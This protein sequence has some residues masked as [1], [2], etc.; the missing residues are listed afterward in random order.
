MDTRVTNLGNELRDKIAS[1]T[2]T[3]IAMGG[4]TILPDTNFT[5][6]GNVGMYEGASAVALNAAGRVS[7]KVYIT[8]AVGGGLN[9]GGKLGGRVGV[10]FGF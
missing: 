8:A 7:E 5:L 2:A 4:S 1:S 3:A 10:V 9:K 6:S